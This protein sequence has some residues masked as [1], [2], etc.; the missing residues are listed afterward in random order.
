MHGA[1]PGWSSNDHDATTQQKT[2]T[3]I[4][5]Y[6]GPNR[7]VSFV[8]TSMEGLHMQLLAR[9][10]WLGNPGFAVYVSTI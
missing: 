4:R 7:P 1:H 10:G 2:T 3:S 6:D 5:F 8:D 9:Y